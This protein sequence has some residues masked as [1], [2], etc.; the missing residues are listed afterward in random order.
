ML[1]GEAV[2]L[3]VEHIYLV[4]VIFNEVSSVRSGFFECIEFLSD[5]FS[6]FI[7][8][9]LVSLMRSCISMRCFLSVSIDCARHRNYR[10]KS[11]K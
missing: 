5:A 10:I 8:Q 3:S 9:L 4:V 11:A 1:G 2:H 7:E 6:F